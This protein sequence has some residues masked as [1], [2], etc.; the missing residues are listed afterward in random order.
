MVEFQVKWIENSSKNGIDIS[1][2]PFSIEMTIIGVKD[3]F[4]EESIGRRILQFWFVPFIENVSMNF[5]IEDYKINGVQLLVE[6][7]EIENEEVSF[8]NHI[9]MR[10]PEES[11]ENQDWSDSSKFTRSRYKELDLNSLKRVLLVETQLNRDLIAHSGLE[12]LSHHEKVKILK[13]CNRQQIN[14]LPFDILNFI[15]LPIFEDMKDPKC[16]FIPTSKM[17]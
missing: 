5:S 15:N 14:Q 11:E 1:K 9:N 3:L 4:L 7:E 6:V 10:N 13:E 17:V 12:I 16:D 8:Y 2:E